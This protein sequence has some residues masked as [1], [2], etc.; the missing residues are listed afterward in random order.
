MMS[1][2][3]PL[4]VAKSLR[5][6]RTGTGAV[7]TTAPQQCE[8]KGVNSAQQTNDKDVKRSIRITTIKSTIADFR[9]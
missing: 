7:Y 2:A 3:L 5:G 4:S 9:H 8:K 1:C 6:G